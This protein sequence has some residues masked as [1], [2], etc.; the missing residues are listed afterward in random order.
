MRQP[1]PAHDWELAP[2]EARALQERLRDQVIAEDRLPPVRQVAGID[3]G[4]EQAGAVARAAVVVLS[5]P[6]LQPL[7]QAVARLPTRF[8]YVPG[9]LSF[10]EIPAVLKALEG[11]RVEPDLLIC[12]G[13]G[14]AHPRRFGLAC[15]LGLLT[16][17]PAIGAAKSRLIGEHDPLPAARG[18][19]VPLTHQGETL[20]A[21]LR[22]R[23]GVTPLFVSI[24]HRI[25]LE[26]A[27]RY[28]L[29][30][31]PR[32]R[33]PETTRLAHRLASGPG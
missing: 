31:C 28:L 13:Q 18:S 10:R 20:G 23:A 1:L 15:H 3:V 6:E 7:D 14:Q 27:I 21:V 8:P 16:D 19:W 26:T 22:T 5:F 11:L 30:C 29:A 12:D 25:S 2:A 33:L 17:R 4:F 24:G 32:Y 9:L